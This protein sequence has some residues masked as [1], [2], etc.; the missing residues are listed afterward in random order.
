MTAVDSASIDWGS[1]PADGGIATA[2]REFSGRDG[3]YT[4]TLSGV[5]IR[6]IVDRLRRKWDELVGEL[7]VTCTIPGARTTDELG[8]ILVADFSLSNLR[9]RQERATVLRQRTQVDADWYGL[10]E[11]FCQRVLNA[12]RL[13]QPAIHLRD[14]EPPGPEKVKSILTA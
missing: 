2:P 5:G 14:L 4:M 1:G 10:I 13:G 12:E 7:T 6:L 8:T 3:A 9:A 11:D